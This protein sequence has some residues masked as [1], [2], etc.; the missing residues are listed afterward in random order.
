MSEEPIVSARPVAVVPLAPVAPIGADERIMVV[1]VL[2]GFALF[3][4][5]LVNM[6]FFTS[7]VYIVM[8]ETPWWTAPA[9]RI[10]ETG[11]RWLAEGKFYVLFSFLFGLGMALQMGRVEARGGR[12]VRLYVRRL[13]VLLGIGLCHALLLWYGDILTL[14]AC[15]GFPLLLFRRR[16]DR[17]LL[18]WASLVYCVPVAIV[19]V[20]CGLVALA[21]LD[22]KGAAE[23]QQQ[24]ADNAAAMLAAAQRSVAVY[25]NGSFADIFRH[26]LEN[27]AALLWDLPFIM[28]VIFTMFLLG[29]Y[30][31]RRG[32]P[33]TIADHP[34]ALR[35][36][37]AWGL[38][39]GLLLNAVYA[40]VLSTGRHAHPDAVLFV[41][42]AMHALGTPLLSGGYAA[43]IVLLVQRTSWRRRLEPLAAVG[44]MALTNYLL[45][46]LICTTLCY[47]YGFR[48]FG[49][50]GP[51]WGVVL[52]IAVYALQVPLSVWWLERFR[53]GPAE[54]IW[55]SLTYWKWQPLSLVQAG[56][57]PPT[58]GLLG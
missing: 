28:P 46:T 10:A 31:G 35:R 1:D 23:V 49:R 50:I 22:P 25:Q 12:F 4:I 41:A 40:Y 20:L 45:Q 53:F 47:G 7:P 56:L 24:M 2:R 5:L 15:L 48:L 42:T 17:T 34:L 11:I 43:V 30:C 19:G 44:R 58:Q 21:G 39:L 13:C 32:L 36:L 8:L 18:W 37:V 16:T 54:W 38:P 55:R 27:H 14:Y 51:A 57:P 33:R 6:A 9:D 52:T 26:R 29:L 3:G